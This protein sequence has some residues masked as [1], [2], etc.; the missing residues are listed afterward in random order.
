MKKHIAGIINYFSWFQIFTQNKHP[1]L[2]TVIMGK[3]CE[4][5]VGTDA[6][7]KLPPRRLGWDATEKEWVT[8]DELHM[9][10]V[11]FKWKEL[12]QACSFFPYQI[13]QASLSL[14]S[15][16][17]GLSPSIAL[18]SLYLY[19][20]KT[21]SC[22][23]MIITSL[24]LHA[25]RE[26]SVLFSAT[27]MIVKEL[28]RRKLSSDHWFFFYISCSKIYRKSLPVWFASKVSFP[29]M[30]SK[31]IKQSYTSDL[32]ASCNKNKN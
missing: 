9:T 14:R 15:G 30:R 19:Y 17:V 21:C 3:F 12:G 26:M 27:R 1:P 16:V 8:W 2:H 5:F 10:R 4:D 32:Q 13:L 22:Y 23:L 20:S 24:R 28:Y 18:A 6:L 7:T 25:Q 29:L 31:C 11:L